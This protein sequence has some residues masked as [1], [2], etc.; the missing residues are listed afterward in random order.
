MKKPSRNREVS[1]N[2]RLYYYAKRS[3]AVQLWP[4]KAP[5]YRTVTPRSTVPLCTTGDL[6]RPCSAV[7]TLHVPVTPSRSTLKISIPSETDQSIWTFQIQ[8]F[9]LKKAS[10][11]NN[12]IKININTERILCGDEGRLQRSDQYSTVACN[13]VFGCYV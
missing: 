9:E 3:S 1:R 11:Q 2:K 5:P 10:K 12:R 13:M 8:I 4:S 6:S 7:L